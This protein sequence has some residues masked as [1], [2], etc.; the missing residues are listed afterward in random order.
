MNISIDWLPVQNY[1]I[2]LEKEGM[3]TRTFRR[4]DAEKQQAIIFAILDEAA[5]QNP[6][7][8][9]IKNVARRADVAVGSLYTYFTNRERMLNFAVEICVRYFVDTFRES[10]PY[11]DSLSLREALRLY[12]S[13]G[14][15]WS[16]DQAAFL[17]L[18][19][20][21]AYGGDKKLSGPL[22]A[23]I[24]SAMFDLV[25]ELLIQ[26]VQRGEIRPDIDIDAAA[27]LVNVLM[28]AVGDS[29]LIPYL[30]HYFLIHTDTRSTEEMIEKLIDF[31]L[32]GIG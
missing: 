6:S 3:V 27:R 15:E 16:R 22:V 17:R 25:K 1:I 20:R 23:P 12:L 4:L 10:R 21:A 14:I 31:I 5:E 18:F 7:D 28:I 24:A 29:K 26:A 9:N 13:Y 8:L 30:N 32:R 2:Q 11:F 19:A